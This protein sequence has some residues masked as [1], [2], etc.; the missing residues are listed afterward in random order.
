M[1][2]PV[3]LHPKTTIAASSYHKFFTV[4][5][6][7]DVMDVMEHASTLL[8]T[9]LDAARDIAMEGDDNKHWA[10]VYLLESTL[11]LVNASVSG[12]LEAK[13]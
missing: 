8:D 1:L 10:V 11:A 4:K 7:L 9:A 6:G 5:P 12:M 13:Q 3:P 2:K